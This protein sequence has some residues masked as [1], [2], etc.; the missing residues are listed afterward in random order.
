[1]RLRVAAVEAL[2]PS[3]S[4][5]E[6]DAGAAVRLFQSSGFHFGALYHHQNQTSGPYLLAPPYVRMTLSSAETS[7]QMAE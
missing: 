3:S 4:L 6:Q 1:M 2:V 5:D 7:Y